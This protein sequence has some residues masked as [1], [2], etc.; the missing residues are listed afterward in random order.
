MEAPEGRGRITPLPPPEPDG[1]GRPVERAPRPWMP[2][3]FALAGL[4][5]FAVYLAGSGTPE[6]NQAAAGNS[7]GTLAPLSAEDTI[8]PSSPPPSPPPT[9][10]PPTLGEML[11]WLEGSL[12]IFSSN[13]GGDYLSVWDESLTEPQ[14]FRLSGSNVT[15]VEPEPTTLSF[16]A[17]ET[18]G[19]V[20][21]LYMGGWQTQEPIFVGSQGFA[22]DPAGSATV[23]FVGTDQVTG[24]TALYS[25]S[26]AGPISRIAPLSAGSRLVGWAH[27][28]LVIAV[29][30]GPPVTI[31]DPNTGSVTVKTPTVTEFRSTA[32]DLVATAIAEPVRVA[33]DGTV[34]AVGSADALATAAIEADPSA[35]TVPDVF[36]VLDTADTITLQSVPFAEILSDGELIFSPDGRWSLSN[37]GDWVARTTNAGIS[38]AIAMRSL[39]TQAVRVVALQSDGEKQTVGFTQDG[40]WFFTY[41]R[42]TN[43]LVASNDGGAQFSVPFDRNVRLEGVY[44]RP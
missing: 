6:T 39:V 10:I 19:R 7:R 44:T 26:V 5:A 38:T 35:L 36:V 42:E 24:E 3:G 43:R 12:V 2:V 28:G 30:L 18:S 21:S 16:I 15:R 9:T 37:D 40:E 29:D 27:T 33:P 34:I 22:W 13:A 25:Q 32:G 14:E 1:I 11:P 23:H 31:I 17:Y 20:S 41:S 8:P 4:L